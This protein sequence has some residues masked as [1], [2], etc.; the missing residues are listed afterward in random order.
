MHIDVQNN[1]EII[2]VVVCKSRK[3]D[4]VRMIWSIY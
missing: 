2:I 1:I 3:D 4:P